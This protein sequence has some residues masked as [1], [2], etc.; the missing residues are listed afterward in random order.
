MNQTRPRNASRTT[1]RIYVIATS[2]IALRVADDNFLRPAGG[3]APTDHLVSGLV[4]LA[5]L[6]LGVGAHGRVRAGA[7]GVLAL[8]TALT[9][10]LV[11]LVEPVSNLA[12]GGFSS[13]DVPGLLAAVAGLVLV[14]VGTAELWR[15]RRQDDRRVRRYARRTVV[16][17]LA[18]LVLSEVWVPFAM[19]YVATH[20]ARAGVPEAQLGAKHEDVAFTT[21]DG[22][23]LRGWYVPSRNGA[24]VIVFPGRQGKQAHARML[25]RHGYGVLLFD[26]RG[27]GASD[28]DPNLFGWGGER[29]VLAA[30]DFLEQ[31]PDVQPG[32]I[33]GLGLSV[34]GELM[35]QA[36]A[37]S[38][39]IAAVVSEGAGTRSLREE[40][41]EFDTRTK[42]RG[43]HSL[44]AKQAGLMLFSIEAPPPCLVDLVP[45]VAPRPTLLI[46]APNGGNRETLNPLY[47]RRIGPSASIWAIR[48]VKHMSGLSGHPEEYERRVVGFFDRA[49]LTPARPDRL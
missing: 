24:A 4:P 1:H 23:R 3:V 20:V 37:R 45:R 19:G 27:E 31:R 26:R 28:G 17:I 49:L 38:R 16:G 36:A 14:G 22:L 32:R 35:L 18:L 48:D 30:V 25:A 8:A 47:R 46:W 21:S 2:V 39:D 6:A 11:G 33:G 9:G 34:G 15:S 10:L 40:L 42:I 13:E 41:V 44:L 12:T 29:D 43:F 5:A 7:R